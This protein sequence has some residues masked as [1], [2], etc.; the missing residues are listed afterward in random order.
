MENVKS[1]LFMDKD[2]LWVSKL[3]NN[4]WLWSFM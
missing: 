4:K 3:W 2:Y 1:N